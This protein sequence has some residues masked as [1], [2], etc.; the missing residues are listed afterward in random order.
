MFFLNE[1]Y[2][3]QLI[4]E[5]HGFWLKIKTQ[6]MIEKSIDQID[7]YDFRSVH[8]LEIDYEND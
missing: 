7:D 1:K 5:R 3:F 2:D 4:D 6:T 8:D